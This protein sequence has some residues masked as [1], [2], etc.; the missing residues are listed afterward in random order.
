[1]QRKL[2]AIATISLTMLAASARAVSPESI[3]FNRSVV[4]HSPG[5]Q[6]TFN[7]QPD[8]SIRHLQS[9]LL[10]P[11]DFPNTHLVDVQIYSTVAGVGTDVGCDYARLTGDHVVAAKLTIFF[12]RASDTTTLASAFEKYRTEVIAAQPGA[13]PVPAALHISD[14]AT[15]ADR[16]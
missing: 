13:V 16:A 10:C 7:V 3:A 12:V 11:A 14:Q 9:G 6:S 1:M 5:A 2:F 4:A 15:H 8:G